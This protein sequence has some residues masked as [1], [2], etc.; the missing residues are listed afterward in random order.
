MRSVSTRQALCS[1]IVETEALDRWIEN[2]YGFVGVTTRALVREGTR[3]VEVTSAAGRH[4]LRLATTEGRSLGEVEEEAC[5]VAELH[6]QGAR[7]AAPVRRRDGRLV[8]LDDAG[9]ITVLF[10]NAPGSFVEQPSAAQATALGVE[11][12][13][14]HA[15]GAQLRFAQRP[16]IDVAS[17]ATRPLAYAERW[18]PPSAVAR[19]HALVSALEPRLADARGFCHGDVH[20]GNVLFDNDQPTLFDLESCGFGPSVYDL[21]CYFRKRVLS[22]AP[23]ED[24]RALLWGYE[25]ARPLSPE[26]RASIPAWATLRAIWVMALPALPGVAWGTDWLAD[27]AY[28]DAHLEMIERFASLA[29]APSLTPSGPSGLP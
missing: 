3:V 16:P 26:E 15:A 20:L 4:W 2:D 7:V 23:A 14:L 9:R 5:A 27:P 25:Q 22:G 13:R 19:V 18:L 8:A 21:A 10:E 17:L 24:W 1:A 28:V 6:A 12:A 11:L 29:N